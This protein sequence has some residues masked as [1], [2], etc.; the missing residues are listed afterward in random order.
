[1]YL[2]LRSHFGHLR[3]YITAHKFNPH[4]IVEGYSNK[5]RKYFYTAGEHIYI[6]ALNVIAL[7]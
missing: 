7:Y 6:V 1:M 4:Y 3:T 5:G 2:H